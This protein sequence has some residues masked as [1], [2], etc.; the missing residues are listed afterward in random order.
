MTTWID[1]WRDATVAIGHVYPT[2]VKRPDGG[3][4]KGQIFVVVGTDPPS[5]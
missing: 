5:G 3:I 2:R 4:F 1:S